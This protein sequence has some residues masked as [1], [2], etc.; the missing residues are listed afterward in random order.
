[1]RRLVLPSMLVLGLACNGGGDRWPASME[2]QPHRGDLDA[3]R[4]APEGAV[5]VGGVELVE[6]RF[7]L[8]EEENPFARDPRS[9]ARGRR[10]FGLHCAACHGRD[11]HGDG[12]VS[13]KVPPVPDLRYVGICRR[14]DGLIYGTLTAGGWAMP[15]LR[16]GLSSRDRWDLVSY[17]RSLQ[18]AG[19]TDSAS[20][21]PA[22][23]GEEP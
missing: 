21:I 5:P 15:S 2:D 17:V 4:P 16:E 8:E 12:P 22:Q 14:T 11:G 1:M 10:L 3:L 7:E 13:E 20:G 23:D 6:D 18:R 19:C 9:V